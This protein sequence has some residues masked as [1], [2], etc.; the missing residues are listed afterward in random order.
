MLRCQFLCYVLKT[1]YI[2]IALKLSYFC[3]K[4]QIFERWGL[5]PQTPKL[6]PPPLRIS[7]YAPGSVFGEDL[8]F[9][10]SPEFREKKCSIFG[11]DLFF[12]LHLICSPE[13]NRGR[14]SSPP[15]LK[16]GQNWGKIANYPPNIQQRFASLHISCLNIYCDNFKTPFRP[17]FHCATAL[18]IS[19]DRM[20]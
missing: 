1:F 15:M 5:R 19:S 6:A 7:V 12:A 8:F 3:K 20:S 13:K 17:L 4:M 2:K 18:L 14:G 10:S 9:W 11:E 16:I